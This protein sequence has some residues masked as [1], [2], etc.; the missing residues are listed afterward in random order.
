MSAKKAWHPNS[1]YPKDLTKTDKLLF[2][3]KTSRINTNDPTPENQ[4]SR[5]YTTQFGLPLASARTTTLDYAGSREELS[6]VFFFAQIITFLLKQ[7]FD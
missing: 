3:E 5:T 1:N 7:Y 6:E 4:L 2:S